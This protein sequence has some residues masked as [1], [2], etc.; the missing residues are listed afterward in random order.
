[1]F[2]GWVVVA[3]CLLISAVI[4]G[5]RYSFGVFFTSFEEEFGLLRAPTSG[6]FAVYMILAPLFAIIG[7]WALDR[8]G[9]R[10][11]LLAMGIVTGIGLF[12]T[13]RVD[14]VWQLYL[15]YSL[16]LAIGTGAA[17][18]VTMSTGTRWF[19]RR[20]ATA[21]A[22]IGSGAGVGTLAMAPT[23]AYLIATFDWRASFV[24]LAVIVWALVLPL[25][26]LLKK[27]PSEIGALPDGEP[28]ATR[29]TA[30]APLDSE[31]G[32]LSLR[33]ALKT[34]SF[35]LFFLTW[36]AYSFCLHLVITHVVPHAEDL[37]IEPVQAAAILSVMAAATIP[38]RILIGMVADRVGRRTTGTVCALLHT[39]AML[40]L[41]GSTEVWMFLVFAVVYGI[42]YGGIDP[43]IVALI[44]DVF[45]L[46]RVGVIMGCL[47]AGWGL[48]AALGP[49]IAGLIFDASGSYTAGFLAG[50]LVMVLAA[51]FISR[52]PVRGPMVKGVSRS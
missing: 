52:L 38:S 47:I 6:L 51:I 32:H 18:N 43:P 34:R 5:I 12:L 10:V 20:R 29:H 23:V 14:S 35:W 48:G 39:V 50:A 25:A 1:V 3:A 15:T 8:Y 11:V 16:L 19:I 21:L 28:E 40:W 9:P 27:E 42:G 13:S 44:G 2:Y 24:A 49:F 17:Y 45:G 4:F 41:I 37:G 22:L 26:W 7:G 33:E 36:F 46:R 30:C 31:P